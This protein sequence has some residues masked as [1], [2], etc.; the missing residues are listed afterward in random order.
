MDG[1]SM[2]LFWSRMKSALYDAILRTI[3]YN[4]P[5]IIVVETKTFR[6]DC[7][8]LHIFG[9]WSLDV[10]T[11]QFASSMCNY[12]PTL[13]RGLYAVLK[14][15]GKNVTDQKLRHHKDSERDLFSGVREIMA[16]LEY[17]RQ[18]LPPLKVIDGILDIPEWLRDHGIIFDVYDA[19]FH[20]IRC[21]WPK[22][23]VVK[24]D[25]GIELSIFG[26]W[27]LNVTTAQFSAPTSEKGL[28]AVLK[29][30]G[31]NVTDQK[32]RHHIDIKRDLFS[33]V[34]EIMQELEYLRK[35]LPH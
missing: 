3:R 18:T 28:Y 1:M 25:N 16:E 30:E 13:D 23:T 6:D 14:F 35:T 22:I 29:F 10:T 31:K 7:I 9:D 21:S 27:S 20:T 26:D 5:E 33:G 11:A 12:A 34:R 2:M 32:L 19:I 17:L 4:W 24:T 15:K 8:E